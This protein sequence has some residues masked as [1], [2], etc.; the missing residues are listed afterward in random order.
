M[1]FRLYL[2]A[3]EGCLDNKE[4]DALALAN[5]HMWLLLFVN[6]LV[7]MLKS[8]VGLQQQLDMLRQFC[9]EHGV[10][11]N[12]KKTKIMVFNSVDPC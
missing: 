4:C 9:A 2:D 10:T 8:K 6:D 1:L 11:V 5:L 12:V 7:L 3:L